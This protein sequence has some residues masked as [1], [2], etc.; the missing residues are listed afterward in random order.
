LTMLEAQGSLCLICQG[1]FTASGF[2]VDHCHSTGRVRGL[3]CSNCNRG[4]GMFQ[5]DPNV[6]RAA[7]SYLAST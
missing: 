4:L 6:L 3:L 5:D 1:E 2:H 7:L